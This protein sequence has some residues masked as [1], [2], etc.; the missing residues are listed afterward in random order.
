MSF[1]ILRNRLLGNDLFPFQAFYVQVTDYFQCFSNQLSFFYNS[2]QPTF[3]LFSFQ[4]TDFQCWFRTT[5]FLFLCFKQPT[6]FHFWQPDFL[7]LMHS[8]FK[9]PTILNL[10]NQLSIYFYL[11]N[12]LLSVF[13]NRLF[14]IF[15][16]CNLNRT[17]FTLTYIQLYDIYKDTHGKHTYTL[18]FI[19]KKHTHT[20]TVSDPS[21]LL[22]I[23]YNKK[24]SKLTVVVGC[25][26]SCNLQNLLNLRSISPQLK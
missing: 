2:R 10:G 7:F 3:I 12:R 11:G 20:Q 4:A 1:S 23:A 21:K 24:N 14:F 25:L 13:Y 6:F 8:T 22:K 18:S 16:L 26:S 5:I 15:Y 17:H 9:Q 19:M